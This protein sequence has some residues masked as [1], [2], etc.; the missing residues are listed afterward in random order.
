MSQES[1][2]VDPVSS[3][4]TAHHTVERHCSAKR[5]GRVCGKTYF[6]TPR[7]VEVIRPGELFDQCPEC[8]A[9]FVE[10]GNVLDGQRIEGEPVDNRGCA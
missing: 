4:S 2:E 6:R 8:F 9:K 3:V 7:S 1:S 5:G 10:E